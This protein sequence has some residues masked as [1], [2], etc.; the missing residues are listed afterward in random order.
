MEISNSGFLQS[1]TDCETLKH[2]IQDIARVEELKI[3]AALDSHLVV[4]LLEA[5]I[6]NTCIKKFRLEST[7]IIGEE[8]T[9]NA[10]C[11]LLRNNEVLMEFALVSVWLGKED[12]DL[13]LETAKSSSLKS[14]ELS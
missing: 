13:I 6:N 10:V 2:I 11:T 5:L 3:E 9:R 12:V 1:E 7:G 4:E 8:E 14:L